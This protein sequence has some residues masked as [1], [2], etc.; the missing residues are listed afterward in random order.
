MWVGNG[1]GGGLERGVREIDIRVCVDV[2]GP[3][4]GGDLGRGCM[5]VGVGVKGKMKTVLTVLA[6]I[7]V[8]Y[9]SRIMCMAL[10]TF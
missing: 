3:V 6:P 1:G 9:A 2:R 4:C 5:E 10:L 7:I 8:L